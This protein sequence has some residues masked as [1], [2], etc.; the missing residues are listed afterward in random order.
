[1]TMSHIE[2]KLGQL[3]RGWGAGEFSVTCVSRGVRR[4][5]DVPQERG[6]PEGIPHPRE[7][8][9]APQPHACCALQYH[10]RTG[11]R[12]APHPAVAQPRASP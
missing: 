3:R 12:D 5:G 1:M 8:R 4:G 6:L 10:T 2:L 7:A 9:G 11:T